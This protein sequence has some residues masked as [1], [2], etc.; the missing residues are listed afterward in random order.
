M[1]TKAINTRRIVKDPFARDVRDVGIAAVQ[2]TKGWQRRQNS[3]ATLANGVVQA[4]S[5]AAYF[6]SDW[7]EWAVAVVLIVGFVAE[8]IVQAT[9]KT[10]VT[11]N[12]VE[13][14]T[15]EAEHA[16]ERRRLEEEA[17]ERQRAE[18]QHA[19]ERRRLEAE[20]AKPT[21]DPRATGSPASER[22]R[23]DYFPTD[24]TPKPYT[25]SGGLRPRP[26]PN[27]FPASSAGHEY[28]D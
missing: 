27:Y 5:V 22:P 9:S 3:I 23:P 7:P 21:P 25:P 11:P 2:R 14:M 16:A 17:A 13:E 28:A 26:R 15:T 20:A 24:A 6:A 10:P 19:A 8:G 12:V 4:V 18:E 1:K